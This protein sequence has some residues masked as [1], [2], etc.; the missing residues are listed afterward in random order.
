MNT[1]HNTINNYIEALQER[2]NQ[3]GGL[4]YAMGFLYSTLKNLKLQSYEL[5]QLQLD[6]ET[7]KAMTAE[8]NIDLSNWNL[9]TLIC[10]ETKT[11]QLLSTSPNLSPSLDSHHFQRML[12]SYQ[13]S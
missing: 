9:Y 10:N 3:V 12:W 1:T 13:A 5:E 11:I 8:D 4:D 7:L 6:T 2:A